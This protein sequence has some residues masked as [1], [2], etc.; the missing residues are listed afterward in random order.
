MLLVHPF[1][2]GDFKN[3][4]KSIYANAMCLFYCSVLFSFKPWIDHEERPVCCASRVF[5]FFEEADPGLKK[6]K[7]TTTDARKR[8]TA[9]ENAMPFS[10]SA[11]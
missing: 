6:K 2:Y 7:G 5:F 9:N 11:F 8:G 4:R 10:T 3:Q 1:F